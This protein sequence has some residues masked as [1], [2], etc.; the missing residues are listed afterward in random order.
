MHIETHTSS[1]NLPSP[2]QSAYLHSLSDTK[3]VLLQY[4]IQWG[5]GE[6]S[7]GA[8]DRLETLIVRSEGELIS[9][10]RVDLLAIGENPTKT[11]EIWLVRFPGVAMVLSHIGHNDMQAL[12][13]QLAY[14]EIILAVMP[15][16][17]ILRIV[18]WLNRILPCLPAYRAGKSLPEAELQG[19]ISPTRAQFEAF[20]AADPS[21]PVHM[22][23][24][25]KFK[26]QAEYEDGDR[27]RTGRRAY[28]DGYG[29]VAMA[30]VLRLKGRIVMLGRYRMTLVGAQ[31]D[32]A[33]GAWDEIAVIQ[34]PNRPAF[35]HMISTPKYIRALVHRHAGLARTEVWSTA[36]A[37]E[38]CR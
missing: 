17:R 27:G 1:A 31:G 12:S 3:P 18:K 10:A 30:C 20:Q 11:D 2:A 38:Y 28:E 34:Y 4:H 6:A 22:F 5:A 19:G 13:Q 26:A 8:A 32:P 7:R 33:P 24:L 35:V 25:L 14:L 37:M 21:V 15:S 36:P 23:N 9:R 16:P 29:R